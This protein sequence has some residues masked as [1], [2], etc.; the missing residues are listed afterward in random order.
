MKNRIVY[1]LLIVSMIFNGLLL[2][3]VYDKPNNNKNEHVM[4][5]R[6][7]QSMNFSDRDSLKKVSDNYIVNDNNYLFL[8]DSIT[9]R[10][11]LKKYYKDLP[12]VN[13]GIDGDKV[14]DIMDNIK[15]RVYDYNPSKIF[16]LIGTNQLKNQNDEEIFEDIINLVDEIHEHRKYTNI[17]VESIYPVNENINNRHT[18]I[19]KNSRIRNINSMLKDYYSNSFVKYIDLYS[20]LSDED[21]NLKKEYS[22]DALHLNDEGYKVVTNVLKNYL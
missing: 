16:L 5:L 12:V 17:Y 14:C 2:F 6:D 20:E 18:K 13:S 3:L 19:R 15:K 8:G 11:D 10:Y 22:D 4:I 21:G 7:F 1:L 9:F